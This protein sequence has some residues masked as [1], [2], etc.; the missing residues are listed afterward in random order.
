MGV[1]SAKIVTNAKKH[2]VTSCAEE[3]V[4]RDG[5]DT[6]RLVRHIPSLFT[7]TAEISARSARFATLDE[8]FG[9]GL[10]AGYNA[11]KRSLTV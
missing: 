5:I 10:S 7:L 4:N 8:K 1:N 11:E 2:C 6:A 3:D 9:L